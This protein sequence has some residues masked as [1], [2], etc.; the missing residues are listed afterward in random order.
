MTGSPDLENLADAELV[1]CVVQPA[2][3]GQQEAAFAWAPPSSTAPP[4]PASSSGSPGEV[5]R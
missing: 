2:V 5:Q 4:A 1:A 3:A